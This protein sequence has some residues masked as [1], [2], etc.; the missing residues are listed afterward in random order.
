MVETDTSSAITQPVSPGAYDNGGHSSTKGKST[1][2]YVG[3][4]TKVPEKIYG[5][6]QPISRDYDFVERYA[7]SRPVKGKNRPRTDTAPS[8]YYVPKNLDNI[9]SD[10]EPEPRRRNVGVEP[11]TDRWDGCFAQG[12]EPKIREE[13]TEPENLDNSVGTQADGNLAAFEAGSGIIGTTLNNTTSDGHGSSKSD[14]ALG[15]PEQLAGS[16][17]VDDS[18]GSPKSQWA[19]ILDGRNKVVGDHFNSSCFGSFSAPHA[20]PPTISP[21]ESLPLAFPERQRSLKSSEATRQS[22]A[23]SANDFRQDQAATPEM[24]KHQSEGNLALDEE[25]EAT[26]NGTRMRLITVHKEK[27][28][29]LQQL[30]LTKDECAQN[31]QACRI[32][33]EDKAE[34]IWEADSDGKQTRPLYNGFINTSRESHINL[35]LNRANCKFMLADYG[36]MATIAFRALAEARKLC[37][38]PLNARC[39]FILGVAFYHSGR[40]NEARLELMKAERDCEDKYGISAKCVQSW[41]DR[42]DNCLAGNQPVYI[43]CLSGSKDYRNAAYAPDTTFRADKFFA[44]ATNTVDTWES[45]EVGSDEDFEDVED[46][47]KNCPSHSKIHVVEGI[48]GARAESPT[49]LLSEENFFRPLASELELVEVDSDEDAEDAECRECVA[50][51]EDDSNDRP[52]GLYGNKA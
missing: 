23:Q 33:A 13:S 20:R 24:H 12:H 4:D 31:H 27:E 48:P 17:L 2:G 15:L 29:A 46:D 7:F 30:R 41:L 45:T 52:A 1:D 51:V 11:H 16:S 8:R 42:C 50:D 25:Q 18:P 38:E 21:T 49:E 28:K 26:L 43:R 44:R 14:L 3:N 10:S 6:R 47:L 40:F 35:L 9:L 39:R 5:R 32:L 34:A 37:F 22:G 36:G 19:G